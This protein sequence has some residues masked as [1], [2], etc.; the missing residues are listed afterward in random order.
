MKRRAF[1]SL[2]GGAAAWPLAAQAQQ[3]ERAKRIGVLTVS[4][5]SDPEWHASIR[6]FLKQL[7]E[8]SN[9]SSQSAN[10]T[11]SSLS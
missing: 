4:A 6:A 5:E 10:N 3:T 7:H 11:T 1:I 9:G 8:L 2:L